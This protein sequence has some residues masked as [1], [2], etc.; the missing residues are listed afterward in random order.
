MD[1]SFKKLELPK[2]GTAIFFVDEDL[3][4]GSL[5]EKSKYKEHVKKAI[6]VSSNFKGKKGQMIPIYAPQG[7]TLDKIVLLGVGK[8]GEVDPKVLKSMGGKVV[9]Y[10]NS[11]KI[12]NVSVIIEDNNSWKKISPEEVVYNIALGAKLKDYSFNHYF[13]DKKEKHK[14]YIKKA[15][16]YTAHD[17]KAKKD[18]KEIEAVTSGVFLTRDLVSQPANVLYPATFVKEIKKMTKLGVKVKVLDKKEMTKLGMGALLGVAQGSAQEPYLAIMEWNGGKKG[19]QP[20]AF[21]GKGVT[22]DTGGI[23]LKPSANMGD[24]KYDMGG[25]GTVTGLMHALAARNAKANVIGVVGLVE[26]MPSGTA[27]RPGD[28]V[29]SMS[30]QTIEIDNTDAEGRLVLAD[31]LWYTQGK[32]KPKFM[33]NLAT[34]TGAIIIALGENIH[35]GLFSNNDTL[36][37]NL[38]SAAEKT[39]EGL[40]RMPLGQEYDD[41]INSVIA[42][43]KNTGQGRGAGSTT[44][45]QFLQRFVNKVP[46]AHI[47]IAGMAWDKKGTGDLHPKGATGYGV[48]LLSQLV[49]DHYEK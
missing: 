28:V 43:V 38:A 11:T 18:Y 41:Q 29:K 5:L 9:N 4:L 8:K 33:I 10:A 26:N 49:K 23:S 48:R 36:A 20:I 31:A 12:S 7:G 2:K 14:T 1:I 21:V 37:K 15:E 46:W 19:D 45:A 44:A 32:Y 25:A 40:W 47:D 39:H 35:A 6:S 22:F 17:A 30:G 3:K 16:F 24:M 42:D 34:L 13:V 27:Q